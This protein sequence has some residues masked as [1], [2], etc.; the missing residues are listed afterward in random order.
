[1][2][3]AQKRFQGNVVVS[4]A[5]QSARAALEVMSQEIGQA[6]FNPPFTP[7]KTCNQGVVANALPQCVT[8]ND[9]QG[10]N[11]GDWVAVDTG[12]NFE[13][14]QVTGTSANGV[15]TSSNQ[16]QARFETNH[17]PSSCASPCTSGCTG[18]TVLPFPVASNKFPYPAGILVGTS[19]SDDHDLMFYGDVNS[20]GSVKYV[21]YSLSPTTSPASTMSITTGTAPGTYTLYNLYRSITPVGFSSSATPGTNQSASVMVENVLYNINTTNPSQSAGPTGLPIFQYPTEVTVGIVP[22]QVTVV[23]TI[24]ITLSVSVNPKRMESGVTEWYS[25]ATQIR[26]LNL[27]AAV[28]INQNGGAQYLVKKPN[29]LPMNNPANYYQ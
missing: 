11:T 22:N 5:N 20:E 10:I 13:Q 19:M 21:V 26:P 15:C 8:L 24:L 1:M 14:V 2:Y 16:I 18:G 9:V 12:P 4:E 7:N 6:G 23:E 17:C 3:Q 25:M 28:A 29:D 27:A